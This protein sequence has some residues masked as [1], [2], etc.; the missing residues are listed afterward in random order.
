MKRLSFQNL[1]KLSAMVVFLRFFGAVLA[2]ALQILLARW[3][4]AGELGTYVLLGAVAGIT[5]IMVC[6]GYPSITPRFIPNY[7]ADERPHLGA[8]FLASSRKHLAGMSVLSIGL[9]L[10]ILL[11]SSAMISDHL[12]LGVGTGLVAAPFIGLMRLN[13]AL[14]LSL[15]YTLLSYLPDLLAKPALL[16]AGTFALVWLSPNSGAI[17]VLVLFVAIVIVLSIMQTAILWPRSNK[18][19]C[20]PADQGPAIEW[21]RAAL[22][23]TIVV[24]LTSFVGDLDI[25]LLAALLPKEDIAI[26]SV[27]FRFSMIT[28]FAIQVVYQLLMPDLSKAHAGGKQGEIV[29]ALGWAN[30]LT[31]AFAGVAT[32]LVAFGGE[33]ILALFGDEFRVGYRAMT[34][35]MAVQLIAAFCGPNAQLLNISGQQMKMVSI[36]GTGLIMLAVLNAILVPKFGL[37]GAAAAFLLSSVYWH[38]RLS[39]AVWRQYGFHGSAL[40]FLPAMRAPRKISQ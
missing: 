25:L 21:R 27:C 36:F 22:P 24:I 37:D 7:M 13:S 28:G 4:G 32:L 39:Y 16:L 30:G 23:M 14:A 1:L 3:L 26:F 19:F 17:P 31:I 12:R 29:Q 33:Q 15:R 18:A 9:G 8:G 10:L 11:Q 5:G 40:G 20:G 2:L 35:L 34:L 6:L 38:G